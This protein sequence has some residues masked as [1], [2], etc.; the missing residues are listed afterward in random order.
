MN[1]R[2]D[3]EYECML[4][5]KYSRPTA[6]DVTQQCS[7]SKA[8]YVFDKIIRLSNAKHGPITITSVNAEKIPQ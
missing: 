1:G 3:H 5:A 8:P 6:V 7:A 2:P 4:V